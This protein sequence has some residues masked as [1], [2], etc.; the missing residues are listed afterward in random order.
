VLSS[1]LLY[2]WMKAVAR[3][4]GVWAVGGAGG[5]E[6]DFSGSA[7]GIVKV[8]VVTEEKELSW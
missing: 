8:F 5:G 2:S 6:G 3:G 4:P 1:A 7:E